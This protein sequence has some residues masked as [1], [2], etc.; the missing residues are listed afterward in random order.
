LKVLRTAV[1]PFTLKHK[2]GRVGLRRALNQQS[3]ATAM[4]D[5]HCR[6][7]ASHRK[8]V[9]VHIFV[10]ARPQHEL[11]T[12]VIHNFHSTPLDNMCVICGVKQDMCDCNA[13]RLAL[14]VRE[15]LIFK[16]Y[17]VVEDYSN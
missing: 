4:L 8:C 14:A 10:V 15:F 16:N 12:Q 3:M 2:K 6:Q 17:Y 9:N 11:Y 13:M 1:L 5:L 7:K